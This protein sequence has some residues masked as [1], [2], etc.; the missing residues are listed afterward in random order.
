ME[1]PVVF[2]NAVLYND[3]IEQETSKLL[4]LHEIV[5]GYI[6][7]EGLRSM[8]KSNV[9]DMEVSAFS[10]CFLFSMSLLLMRIKPESVC[11]SVCLF[12]CLSVNKI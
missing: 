3:W 11:E 6:F 8:S 5:K 2:S 4:H 1:K 12:V 9:K 7:F 10:E